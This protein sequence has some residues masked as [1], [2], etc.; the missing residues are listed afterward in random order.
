MS[1][2]GEALDR[3]RRER[4]PIPECVNIGCTREATPRHVLAS[5]RL[6]F[7]NMCSRCKGQHEAHKPLDSG[8]TSIKKNVCDNSDGHRGWDCPIAYEEH[9]GYQ[10]ITDHEDPDHMNNDPSNLN[11]FCRFCNQ[12]KSIRDKNFA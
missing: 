12:E 9:K 6:S 10:F 5:G 8:I 7:H 2:Q 11:N 3:Y 4:L 1:K